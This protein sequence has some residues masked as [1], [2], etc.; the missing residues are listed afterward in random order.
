MKSFKRMSQLLLT[1]GTLAAMLA[2][3]PALSAPLFM[4]DEGSVPGTA[5]NIVTA[6]RISF[7]Y[8]ARIDQT[9]NGGSLAGNDDPFIEHG[10]LTKAAFGS[11]EGGSIPSQLNSLNGYGI[12]GL[13]TI[14]GEADPFGPSGILATFQTLTMQLWIDADQDTVLNVGAAGPATATDATP[15]DDFV[16]AN[17]TLNVGEAHVF[18]G[19]ANG[20][21]DTLTH[22]SLT[23]AG[24]AFFIDPDPFF[25]LEN[26]GGNTQTFTGGSLT[27]SFT[28]FADGGG[29]EL[30]QVPEPATTAL[31]G[32]GLLGMGMANRRRNKKA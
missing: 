21:F 15:G 4:V 14:T 26:F 24:E 29:L 19:L 31:L 18:A 27:N 10:F 3:A 30:F 12:Y 6:D 13:F 8:H 20:D 22:I 16:I 7:E 11:P 2:S 5:P 32:L 9:I 1:S 25:P 28:G 17:F 23:P